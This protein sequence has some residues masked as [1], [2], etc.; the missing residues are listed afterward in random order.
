MLE[1][2]IN[3]LPVIWDEML[4]GIVTRHDLLSAFTRDDEELADEIRESALAGLRWPEALHLVIDDGCVRLSGQV[5]SPS[6]AKA[7]PQA[8]RNVLG[9]VS[10]DAELTA[11]DQGRDGPVVVS[12]HL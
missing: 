11:W 3:R 10:V 12:T 7:L 1:Y 5:D 8:V 9:V 6:A 2:G 4:V